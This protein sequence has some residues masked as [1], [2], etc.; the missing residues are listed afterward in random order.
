MGILRYTIGSIFTRYKI[1]HLYIKNIMHIYCYFVVGIC[2]L[3]Y[4]VYNVLST[5]VYLMETVETCKLF[6]ACVPNNKN[7]PQTYA[8][9]I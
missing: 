2:F 4:Y 6:N 3:I 1:F 5:C 7:I 9:G 8:P